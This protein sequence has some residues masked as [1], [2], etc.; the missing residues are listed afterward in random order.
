METAIHQN[1]A[2]G[3]WQQLSLPE[4]LGNIGS[5]ISRTAKW[6]GKDKEI[7]ENTVDR[8]LELFDLTL[9]DPRW[10]GRLQ[11]IARAREVFCDII[12]GDKKYKT[13]LEDLDKYFTQFAFM[14]RLQIS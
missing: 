14:A 13:S 7:F 3:R 10:K 11:E 12:F 8:A 9:D 5:E 2:L 4:Q 1:L 6:Q